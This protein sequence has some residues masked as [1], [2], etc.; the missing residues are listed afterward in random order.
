M[1]LI[2]CAGGWCPTL[3]GQLWNVLQPIYLLALS[4]LSAHAFKGSCAQ[5]VKDF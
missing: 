4:I 3:D 1:R 2:L 5:V